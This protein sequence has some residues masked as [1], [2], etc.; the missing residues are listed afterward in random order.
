M[1]R[2]IMGI[3]GRMDLI[4]GMRFHSLIFAAATTV[5]MVG[6]VFLHKAD[7]FLKAICQRKFASDIGDG[8]LWKNAD[9]ELDNIISSIEQVWSKKCEIKMEIKERIE[10]LKKRELLNMRMVHSLLE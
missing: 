5:P 10:E 6:I 2:E 7:C 9:I 8:V 4:I 1:P 3:I